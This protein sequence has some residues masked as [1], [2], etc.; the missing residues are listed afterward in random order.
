MVLEPILL[1][2][3]PFG[4]SKFKPEKINQN[5]DVGKNQLKDYH[6]AVREKQLEM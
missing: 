2:S 4:A 5:K 1:I 6:F 3:L